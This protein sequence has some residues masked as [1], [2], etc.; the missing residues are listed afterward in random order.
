MASDTVCELGDALCANRITRE[1]KVLKDLVLEQCSVKVAR[2][3]VIEARL[4]QAR[5]V[6][7]GAEDTSFL[8]RR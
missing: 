8:A 6:E 7:S 2:G 5:F 1:V 4:L 3:D